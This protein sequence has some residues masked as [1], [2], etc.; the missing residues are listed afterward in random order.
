MTEPADD[1]RARKAVRREWEAAGRPPCPVCE[2]EFDSDDN[3]KASLLWRAVVHPFCA[4]AKVTG[5]SEHQL[6]HDPCPLYS[7]CPIPFGNDPRGFCV[8]P[9]F[10]SVNTIILARRFR[11]PTVKVPTMFSPGSQRAA[12][13]AGLYEQFS[14]MPALEIPAFD[15]LRKHGTLA[16]GIDESFFKEPKDWSL[17][18]EYL[19]VDVDRTIR[20]G[21]VIAAVIGAAESQGP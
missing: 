1:R 7:E 12:R 4:Y 10:S 18:P 20:A 21:R 19:T 8:C 9:R 5:Q 16:P 14:S 3:G 2:T 11:Q 17:P 6:L 15:L 13:N